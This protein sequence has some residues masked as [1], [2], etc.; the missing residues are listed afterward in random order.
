MMF[1]FAK[2]RAKLEF[3]SILIYQ[4]SASLVVIVTILRA[5]TKLLGIPLMPT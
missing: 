4:K 3:L 2:K 5:Q 1:H